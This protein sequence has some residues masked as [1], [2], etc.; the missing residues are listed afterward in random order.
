MKKISIMAQ[1]VFFMKEKVSQDGIYHFSAH[2]AS[3]HIIANPV[4]IF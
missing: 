4:N 3:W 2:E 1:L